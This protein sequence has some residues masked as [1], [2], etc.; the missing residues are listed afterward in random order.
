[1]FEVIFEMKYSSHLTR[2]AHKI[3]AVRMVSK[4]LSVLRARFV[5]LLLRAII[6]IISYLKTRHVNLIAINNVIIFVKN[7]RFL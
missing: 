6:R 1:M 3:V 7:G 5:V 2:I 4:S